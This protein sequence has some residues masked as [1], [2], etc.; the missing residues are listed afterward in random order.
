MGAI[1]ESG[2]QWYRT[3][4]GRQPKETLI[5]SISERELTDLRDFSSKKPLLTREVL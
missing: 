2:K 5:I 4:A 3:M 1:M